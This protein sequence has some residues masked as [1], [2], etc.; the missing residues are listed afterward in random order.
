M[1]LENEG[2]RVM[3]FDQRDSS[4]NTFGYIYINVQQEDL[5]KAQEIIKE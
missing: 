3:I 1:K 2:I 5:I 4:Y